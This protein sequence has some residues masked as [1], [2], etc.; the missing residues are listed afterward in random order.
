[1]R[2]AV[3]SRLRR[4]RSRSAG[5]LPD[6]GSST[7]RQVAGSSRTASRNPRTASTSTASGSRSPGSSGITA[8]Q[9]GHRAGLLAVAERVQ[10]AVQVAEQVVDDRARHAGLARDGLDRHPREAGP[11]GQAQRRVEELRAALLGREAPGR[12]GAAG[13]GL[14]ACQGR[15]LRGGRRHVTVL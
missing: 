7:R 11:R 13:I 1:M 8:R 14:T 5:G 4:M 15:C 3:A 9:R 6:G 12:L 10:Q 2:S